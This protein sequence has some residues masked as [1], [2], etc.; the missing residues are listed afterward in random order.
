MSFCK[1]CKETWK[2]KRITFFFNMKIKY[3][4]KNQNL[5]KFAPNSCKLSKLDENFTNSFKFGIF[6][7]KNEQIYQWMYAFLNNFINNWWICAFEDVFSKHFWRIFWDFSITQE[8]KYQFLRN[9]HFVRY[10]DFKF[11]QIRNSL[12]NLTKLKFS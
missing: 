4:I 3:E 8:K 10:L 5:C 2:R 6:F 12:K 1:S 11:V 9:L 7:L